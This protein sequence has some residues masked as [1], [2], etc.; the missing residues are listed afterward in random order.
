[1]IAY[2]FYQSLP[3]FLLMSPLS[4]AWPFLK[5][6]DL[7]EKRKHR[8]LLEF[9]EALSILCSFLSA[10]LST[11]NAFRAS[12][13]E[14]TH[15]FSEKAMIVREFRNIEY[16]L[17]L[18]KPLE[19]LLMDFAERSGLDDIGNFAEVFSVAK[20]SG[21]ELVSIMRHASDVIRDKVSITE[22]ILTLNASKS[23]EQKIMNIVP[24]LIIIYMNVSSPD[25]F[26]VLYTTFIGRVVMTGCLGVYIF[27]VWLSN[28]ILAIEV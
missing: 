2:A 10:G 15:L 16:G 13:P 11:E 26:N 3:V 28:R 4:L 12:I 25:F 22:E 19:A 20:R 5:R 24:F 23:Y 18:N 1:M 9:K 27:A 6:D 7:C 17:T 14:L 8:L 21:G